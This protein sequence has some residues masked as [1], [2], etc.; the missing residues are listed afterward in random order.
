MAK[1]KEVIYVSTNLLDIDPLYNRREDY[2]DMEQ[3]K[4]SIVENGV[5]TPLVVYETEDDKGDIHYAII[6][7]YRRK[8]AIR[9]LIEEDGYNDFSI[10]VIIDDACDKQKMLARI[11]TD[12]DRK[13]LT[14]LEK[15]SVF[16]ILSERGFSIREIAKRCGMSDTKVSNYLL[17]FYAD[18][19]TKALIRDGKLTVTDAIKKLK[20][21]R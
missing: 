5:I 11:I 14:P 2:G 19:I 17:L 8:E 7:G 13:P 16:F 15:S 4:D 3:L 12:N 21:A 10:P 6:S 18:E 9:Q 1:K 20:K